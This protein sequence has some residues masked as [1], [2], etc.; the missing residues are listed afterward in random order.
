MPTLQPCPHC[1]TPTKPSQNTVRDHCQND[2]C[3]WW[4]CAICRALI[5]PGRH[6]HPTDHHGQ[7]SGRLQA[8]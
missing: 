4:V 2:R 3:N 8:G 6:Y 7:C 1:K 5:A